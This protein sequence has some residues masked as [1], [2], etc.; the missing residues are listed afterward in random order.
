MAN[1][2][3][4]MMDCTGIDL[5]DATAQT[6][7]GIYAK[8]ERALASGKPVILTGLV[9]DDLILGPVHATLTQT[10]STTIT[11]TFTTYSVAVAK[12]STATVTDLLSE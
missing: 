7:A 2:G 8:A 5:D 3:Y 10:A 11:A 6:V 1:P 12:P 4:Y 9:D